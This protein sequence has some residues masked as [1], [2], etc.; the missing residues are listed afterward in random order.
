MNRIIAPAELS[1]LLQSEAA[2]NL[3]SQIDNLIQPPPLQEVFFPWLT[4]AGLSLTVCRADLVH[5][6]LSGNKAFKLKYNLLVARALGYRRLISFGGAYSN[7][8]HALAAA[9][10]LFDFDCIGLVRGEEHARLNPTLQEAQAWGMQ[11]R[12]LSR[13]DYRRREQPEFLAELQANFGPAWLIPEGGSNELALLGIAELAQSLKLPMDYLLT[14]VGSAATYAGLLQ[15]LPARVQLV[16][17]AVIKGGQ[18]GLTT[19][20]EQL[21]AGQTPQCSGLWVWD[22]HQGGYGKITPIVRQ[23]IAAWSEQLPLE[24]FYTAKVCVALQHL[25]MAGYFPVGSR[26]VL[27]H[28][29]GLQGWRTP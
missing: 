15:A 25:A 4:Q 28:T 26:L 10:R 14:A 7:H 23:L 3:K 1:Q 19:K 27:L 9:G 8:L 29:G 5:P 22:Q 16:G 12:Y 13:S 21:L 2:Q 20:V 6:L 11:L 18:Q 17:V 24:P